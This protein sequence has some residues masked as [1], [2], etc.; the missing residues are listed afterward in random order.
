MEQTSQFRVSSGHWG[1]VGELFKL[2]CSHRSRW[3]P[4]RHDSSCPQPL[5]MEFGRDHCWDCFCL[6]DSVMTCCRASGNWLLGLLP[7]VTSTHLCWDHGECESLPDHCG[8]KVA[9][10]SWIAQEAPQTAFFHEM[11]VQRLGWVEAGWCSTCLK[12]AL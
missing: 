3:E 4:L 5:Q 11:T 7:Q 8:Q 10:L 12:A 6:G 1:T 2:L 9:P